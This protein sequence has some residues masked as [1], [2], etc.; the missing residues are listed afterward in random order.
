ML[1]KEKWTSSG[2]GNFMRNDEANSSKNKRSFTGD[3]KAGKKNSHSGDNLFYSFCV[4]NFIPTNLLSL[5]L[6]KEKRKTYASSREKSEARNA[7][8]YG[9]A[10]SSKNKKNSTENPKAAGKQRFSIILKDG[11][12][13]N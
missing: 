9:L 11:S 10:S 3:S 2:S 12:D 8:V 1:A 13:S 5:M 4:S 6:T 7:E